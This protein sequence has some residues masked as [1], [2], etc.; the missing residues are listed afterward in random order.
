M[1][2]Y[3]I[4]LFLII[5]IAPSVALASWWNPFTWKVFKKREPAP[6]VQVI[7]TE[8]NNTKEEEFLKSIG[9]KYVEEQPKNTPS[10]SSKKTIA[11]TLSKA[12]SDTNKESTELIEYRNQV[13]SWYVSEISELDKTIRL[14]NVYKEV[15]KIKISDIKT[16]INKSEGYKIGNPNVVDLVDYFISLYNNQLKLENSVLENETKVISW[17]SNLKI[18]WE[19]NLESIKVAST[20]DELNKKMAELQSG[21]DNLIEAK[22][23]ITAWSEASQQYQEKLDG[24][25]EGASSRYSTETKYN[26]ITPNYPS[27]FSAPVIQSN[28]LNCTSKIDFLGQL[29]TN[30]Y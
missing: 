10:I 13:I 24:I 22:K 5:F 26:N 16:S 28:K 29:Q 6:Q 3:L 8:N 2:K 23:V 1:K 19:N 4:P 20:K 21:K 17:M 14:Q 15:T 11:Q 18:S 30:C 7:N 9:G 12:K 25:I 27:A